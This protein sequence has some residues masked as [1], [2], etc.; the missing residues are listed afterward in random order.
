MTGSER[1]AALA[2]DRVDELRR[3]IDYL[4]RTVALLPASQQRAAAQA[5]VRAIDY[6]IAELLWHLGAIEAP[7]QPPPARNRM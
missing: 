7:P 1:V 6:D 2:T 4:A 5:A 3:E